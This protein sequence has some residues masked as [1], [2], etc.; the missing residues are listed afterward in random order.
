MIKDFNI[1]D[2]LRE[3]GISTTYLDGM[4]PKSLEEIQAA[5]VK[6]GHTIIAVQQGTDSVGHLEGYDGPCLYLFTPQGTVM[7]SLDDK[8]LKTTPHSG[9]LPPK[10]D[11]YKDGGRVYV[12]A[13]GQT[14]TSSAT[15]SDSTR[16]IGN[17]PRKPKY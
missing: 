9:N 8:K 1:A 12:P 5:A 2:F 6:A 4:V 15:P 3:T 16:F 14:P 7:V 10:P 17:L 11:G 13:S